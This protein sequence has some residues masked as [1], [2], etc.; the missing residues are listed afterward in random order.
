MFSGK[1]ISSKV[2]NNGKTIGD[3]SWESNQ[4]KSYKN[5]LLNCIETAGFCESHCQAPRASGLD[6]AIAAQAG[7]A[8]G[9]G[10]PMN[11]LKKILQ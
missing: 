6:Y 3:F 7:L 5:P 8:A 10:F 9:G 1:K 11:F 2:R 4:S